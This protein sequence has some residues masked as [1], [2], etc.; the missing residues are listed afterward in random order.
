MFGVRIFASQATVEEVEHTCGFLRVH[1]VLIPWLKF[2]T[3]F[4]CVRY[5]PQSAQTLPKQPEKSVST[6]L[7]YILYE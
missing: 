3:S 5:N 1:T 2:V 4:P 6:P 7:S